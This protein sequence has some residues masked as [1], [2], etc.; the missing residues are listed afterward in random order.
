[1]TYNHYYLASN[2]P[3]WGIFIGVAL[4][5]VAYIDKK[6]KWMTAGWIILIATGL[7]SLWFN[8]AGNAGTAP[9]SRVNALTTAGWQCVTGAALAAAS[10]LFQRIKNRYFN[11]L[12]ILTLLYF[13]LVFFQFNQL[14][15]DGSKEKQPTEQNDQNN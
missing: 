5:I 7:I 6:E 3:Q 1:M 8:L 2:I 13:M 14:M 11:I 4:V 10:W 15:R 12:A 9:D